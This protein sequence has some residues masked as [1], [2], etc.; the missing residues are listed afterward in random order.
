MNIVFYRVYNKGRVAQAVFHRFDQQR[1]E[2]YWTFLKM[3]FS[4][5]LR[6]LINLLI[7]RTEI[8]VL[9]NI[10]ALCYFPVIF[11]EHT[12]KEFGFMYA[13]KRNYATSV[14]ISTFM[15]L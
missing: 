13:Q 6:Q 2:S 4:E 15:C 8:Y 14:P 1:S 11:F 9:I 12:A 10:E 7:N 3:G 5:V